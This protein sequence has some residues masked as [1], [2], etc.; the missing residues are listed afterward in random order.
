MKDGSL[1]Y[2]NVDED[3]YRVCVEETNPGFAKLR[4][5]DVDS[6]R[7]SDNPARMPA[8]SSSSLVVEDVKL[9]DNQDQGPGYQFMKEL[10]EHIEKTTGVAPLL[11]VKRV[12]PSTSTTPVT[13]MSPT[14][15]TAKDGGDSDDYG[16]AATSIALNDLLAK[17]GSRNSICKLPSKC[18]KTVKVP[19]LNA[20]DEDDDEPYPLPTDIEEERTYFLSK[21]FMHH[22]S[23]TFYE[24]TRE[25]GITDMASAAQ[26]IDS[27]VR[28]R[29]EK[30]ESEEAKELWLDFIPC[31]EVPFWPDSGIEWY[32]RPRKK[33]QH[34]ATGTVY[35]WPPKELIT[36]GMGKDGNPVENGPQWIGATLIPSRM[37]KNEWQWQFVKMEHHLLKSLNHP[38]TRFFLF[39]TLLFRSHLADSTGLDI[40][41][42]R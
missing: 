11:E 23:S 3:I 29:A 35:H 28:C 20:D 39:V 38:Q 37:V 9:D 18:F 22:F 6:R 41:F 17:L 12:S 36:V 32:L 1:D 30:I 8:V 14:S 21:Y 40:S 33:F 26:V 10:S 34:K 42:L 25:M 7:H 31:I 5:V 13:P 4:C 27:R 2:K 24:M 15:P 16:Y 19:V